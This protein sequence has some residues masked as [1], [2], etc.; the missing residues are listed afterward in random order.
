MSNIANFYIH[1]KQLITTL[2]CSMNLKIYFFKINNNDKFLKSREKESSWGGFWEFPINSQ[3]IVLENCLLKSFVFPP[4]HN[5]SVWSSFFQHRFRPKIWEALLEL[6]SPDALGIRNFHPIKSPR[7]RIFLE[8]SLKILKNCLLNYFWSS[9]TRKHRAMS[10]NPV[11]HANVT[12][13][14]A[15]NFCNA[16]LE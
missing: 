8:N 5:L 16:C 2:F 3:I 11:F 13:L 9:I 12:I 4:D 14:H 6:Q 10:M 15:V 7:S 1:L